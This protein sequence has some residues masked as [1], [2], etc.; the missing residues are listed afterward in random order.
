MFRDRDRECPCG[1]LKLSSNLA[2]KLVVDCLFAL[3]LDTFVSD[4]V[5]LL[6]ERISG[7]AVPSLHKSLATVFIR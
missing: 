7:R 1:C 2:V 6:I 5:F 3:L 4:L